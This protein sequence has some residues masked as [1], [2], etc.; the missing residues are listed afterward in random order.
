MKRRLSLPFLLLAA[1]CVT[2]T[3]APVPAPQPQ[4]DASVPAPVPEGGTCPDVVASLPPDAG[5]EA[6]SETGPNTL[7]PQI[8]MLNSV[9]LPMKGAI[10]EWGDKRG[11]SVNGRIHPHGSPCEWYVEYGPTDE[12]GFTSKT[13]SLPGRLS[14][15]YKETWNYNSMAGYQGGMSSTNL[16]YIN[17]YVR[18]TPPG[19][20]SG[21]DHNH[22]SGVGVLNLPIYFYPGTYD[23]GVPM[24]R[25]GGTGPDM[26]GAIMSMK[27]HG[28]GYDP[29]GTTLSPWMQVGMRDD[30]WSDTG[31]YSNWAFSGYDAT[32]LAK[33]GNWENVTMVLE[34]RTDRWSY[35]GRNDQHYYVRYYYKELD[36]TL[37][38]LDVDMFPLQIIGLDWPNRW[39]N[40]LLD[41]D[42]FEITYRQH[43]LLAPSNGGRLVSAT[44]DSTLT[45]GWRHGLGREW[46]SSPNP[47]EPQDIVFAFERPVSI[48]GVQIHNS[49]VD[50]SKDVEISVSSDGGATWNVIASGTLPESVSSGPNFAYLYFENRSWV[51]YSYDPL[52][53]SPVTLF[54][55]RVLS[56]YNP[57]RWGLG[58]IEAFGMGALEQTE[59]A[60]Y[61]VNRDIVVT[62]G[63]YHYRLV[64]KTPEG[65]V[66][67]PDQV[68]E[69]K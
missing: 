20:A 40:G 27:L 55:V 63:V 50:P 61:D 30:L 48:L 37:A 17:G 7:L 24:V 25:M 10:S 13:A 68:V 57:V 69:V 15:H 34:N 28:E 35:A 51:S 8:S 60:W 41:F 56:G 18:Y 3:Q 43:S 11:W 6:S 31:M 38:H 22:T 36:A 54:K 62:P 1:C 52:H 9:A 4:E 23:G 45:D 46:Y 5:E 42:D 33:T 21:D 49:I 67:G 32:P 12:Y 58:E 14:A 26:R 53:P 19:D 64:A 66:R 44:G 39:P 65:E 2:S 29:A 59:D 47:T 16:S